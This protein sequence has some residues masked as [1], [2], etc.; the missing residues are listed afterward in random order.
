MPRHL[1]FVTIFPLFLTHDRFCKIQ[2]TLYMSI[3]LEITSIEPK[4]SKPTYQNE[5]LEQILQQNAA[6]SDLNLDKK[7]LT[8]DDMLIVAYFG[9]QQNTVS[10]IPPLTTCE[11]H[12]FTQKPNIRQV[13]RKQINT[14]T[15]CPIQVPYF[16]FFS[17]PSH[18]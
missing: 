8:D 15:Q 17:K 16:P 6:N 18:T 10:T 12:R 14:I 13:Q 4:L 2:S 7:N 3:Y 5:E 9:I 11:T 1:S